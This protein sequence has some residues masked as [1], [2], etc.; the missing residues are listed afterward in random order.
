MQY[1]W[2]TTQC[3]LQWELSLTRA[4]PCF[5]LPSVSDV[6]RNVLSLQ[7][8]FLP[9]CW[10]FPSKFNFRTNI[11]ACSMFTVCF[12]HLPSHGQ[13]VIVRE[14]NFIFQTTKTKPGSWKIP[15]EKGDVGYPMN[16]QEELRN[17]EWGHGIS[18]TEPL[19]D[20]EEV[21]QL[22]GEPSAFAQCWDS[23][24]GR[25]LA[26][27]WHQRQSLQILNLRLPSV[28]AANWLW[29]MDEV[30]L[31]LYTNPLVMTWT[32]W[33]DDPVTRYPV[34][35]LTSQQMCF[36]K[37]GRSCLVERFLVA[38]WILNLS[39]VAVQKELKSKA[40]FFSQLHLSY[41]TR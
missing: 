41:C 23:T 9:V 3:S 37:G 22:Q 11:M 16:L 10:Q 39:F 24:R 40:W 28:T 5:Q 30:I 7:S 17:G 1:P 4:E 12:I 33:W 20:G 6:V 21:W 15:W 31:W 35:Q 29:N 13:L 36:W 25:A 34:K 26:R 19:A 18:V 38:D 27:P 8:A 14:C 2:G 32:P